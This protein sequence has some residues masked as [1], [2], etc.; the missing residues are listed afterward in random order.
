MTK[1]TYEHNP[2]HIFMDDAA[3]FITAAIYQ[4]RPL[5]N[6]PE[7]KTNLLQCIQHYFDQ[8]QWLLQHWV[9]LD[10]HYHLLGH[11]HKGHELP[12]LINEIHSVSGFHIKHATKTH[13]QVWWNYWD[14]C[15]RDE[16]DY[17]L[18]LNYLL[19]NPVKHG[20]T[21]QL[22]GYPFSSFHQTIAD[23]GREHLVQ[24][25]KSH[26]GYKDLKLPEDDF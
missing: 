5:L 11:S 19:M 1:K 22:A 17:L 26:P 2:P 12:K 7:L 25:F 24:Q 15:P 9:I 18:R 16:N 8:H 14:Y 4:K 13:G 10:N 6:N 20:Y 21:T 3:Y 23:C